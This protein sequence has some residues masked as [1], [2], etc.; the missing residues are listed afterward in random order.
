M[1][2]LAS[3]ALVFAAALA[4]L[5]VAASL[6]VGAFDCPGKVPLVQD[7][8]VVGETIY[9]CAA[10]TASWWGLLLGVVVGAIAAAVVLGVRWRV[11]HNADAADEA[12][13]QGN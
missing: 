8:V 12:V 2:R 4:G 7:G 5:V 9:D 11:K 3:T 13:P 6:R 10:P 1:S